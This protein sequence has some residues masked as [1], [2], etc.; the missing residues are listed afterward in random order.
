M[1]L[2]NKDI[3]GIILSNLNTNEIQ[4]FMKSIKCVDLLK[5]LIKLF[6]NE[7][8]Y[9]LYESSK[10]AVFKSEI[11]K[12]HYS[13]PVPKDMRKVHLYSFDWI[14][15]LKE[16]VFLTYQGAKVIHI[17]IN[18]KHISIL[19]YTRTIL[20]RS[21]NK[22]NS[23]L[24][25]YYK[26]YRWK[27]KCLKVFDS[28]GSILHDKPY[29]NYGVKLMVYDNDK[30]Y[31][32]DNKAETLRLKEL[33]YDK[34]SIIHFIKNN[35]IQCLHLLS[36]YV[37]MVIEGAILLFNTKNL[38]NVSLIQL[39]GTV[40]ELYSL[41]KNSAL[42]LH[43]DNLLYELNI[44]NNSLKRL[45]YE[46]DPNIQRY[47]TKVHSGGEKYFIFEICDMYYIIN[48]ANMSCI[49]QG[50]GNERNSYIDG[51][52]SKIISFNYS[53]IKKPLLLEI[54]EFELVDFSKVIN[55]RNILP[56]E[57]LGIIW[58]Y[59]IPSSRSFIFESEGRVYYYDYLKNSIGYIFNSE[60]EIV[61][62]SP[63]YI[64]YV[65]KE[66]I[67]IYNHKNKTHTV[68][69]SSTKINYFYKID[70]SLLII[71]DGNHIKVYDHYLKCFKYSTILSAMVRKWSKLFVGLFY[72][73]T[74]NESTVFNIING[75]VEKLWS[76]PIQNFF[77][78]Y[79]NDKE[80]FVITRDE[81]M[82]CLDSKSSLY[83]KPLTREDIKIADLS[84]WEKKRLL[85]LIKHNV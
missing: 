59:Q 81:K 62:F 28:E 15:C 18:A 9:I 54:R 29:L 23:T 27:R 64:Y 32:T 7:Q 38:Q 14:E 42:V 19:Q 79:Y 61:P 74:D 82:I 83:V 20:T 84:L 17:N 3:N 71:H 33:K 31:Y 77:D 75:N 40:R 63:S 47:N 48:K 57:N 56:N 51:I 73:T 34:D 1:K 50:F 6:I 70:N 55:L 41:T 21:I 5:L 35:K 16:G 69:L 13:I 85:S 36:Q 11:L 22:E 43:S 25:L 49:Y 72:I 10:N 65:S 52:N 46:F 8:S 26:D 44:Q 60:S 67:I 30:L 12:R 45:F 24:A 80:A 66:G 39:N 37:F 53:K 4:I 58:E 2:L 78:I 76:E 68:L